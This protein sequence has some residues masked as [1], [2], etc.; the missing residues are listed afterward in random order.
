M[1]RAASDDAPEI[2]IEVIDLTKRF[3]DVA[4][5]KGISFRVP[6]GMVFGLVGPNGAGKSTTVKML[7]T[8]LAPSSGTARVAGFDVRQSPV[9]VRRRIGYVPQMQSAD[10]DLTGFENLLVFAR[11]YA[12]PRASRRQRILDALHAMDL[13]DARDRLARHYSGGM[14]RRLEIA[15]SL[16]NEPD[17]LFM[18]EPTIGLDP[19]ARHSVWERVGHLRSAHGT[20]I[21]MTTHYMDE[22]A[23]LC[24]RVAFMREGRIVAEES[25]ETISGRYG[26][27]VTLDDLFIR[28]TGGNASQP[29]ER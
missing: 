1:V 20:T 6:R 3:G 2:A 29:A 4:A 11:L 5:V 24:T 13:D 21:F 17:V 22:A 26:A 19:L 25:P 14:L 9:A 15:Q 27:D 23:E 18:D 16:L 12:L 7:T 10:P 8:L 28:Y